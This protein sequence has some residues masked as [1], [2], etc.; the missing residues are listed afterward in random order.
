M[1]RVQR[2]N[3]EAILEG[4][5]RFNAIVE[6]RYTAALYRLGLVFI[7]H[8]I[9]NAEYANLTG[10]TITSIAF[11]IFKNHALTDVIFVNQKEAIRTKLIRGEVV[12][13]FID[14]DG[15]ERKRFYAKIDTDGFYGKDTTMAFLYKFSSR[16]ANSIVVTTGTEYSEFLD[17]ELDLNVL[18]DTRDYVKADAFS[19]FLKNFKKIE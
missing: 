16:Y 5:K 3:R 13:N 17:Q 7:E 8:A 4:M 12:S 1:P 10:N 19:L 9:N 14:Y 6:Q 15:N 2:D 18:T 11:G